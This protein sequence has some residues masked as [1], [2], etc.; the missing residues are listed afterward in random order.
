MQDPQR[1]A[2]PP[3]SRVSAGDIAIEGAY[4]TARRARHHRESYRNA[5]VLVGKMDQYTLDDA[6]RAPPR[7]L[8]NRA[9]A[10]DDPLGARHASIEFQGLGEKYNG[11]AATA[12]RCPSA[13]AR[14]PSP[15]REKPTAPS[16]GKSRP[17][18]HP[19]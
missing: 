19:L 4:R 3:S 17:Q 1:D 9:P 5:T 16:P 12:Q 18:V 13:E 10:R 2:L 14:R 8:S 15:S 11:F 7:R 6:P